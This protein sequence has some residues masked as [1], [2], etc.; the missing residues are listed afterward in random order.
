[1]N[2]GG[3]R[4]QSLYHKLLRLTTPMLCAQ[5]GLPARMKRKEIG[6]VFEL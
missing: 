2:V 5:Q 1:M 3:R 4:M 6:G